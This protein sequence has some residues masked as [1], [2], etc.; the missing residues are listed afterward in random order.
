MAKDLR[1]AM[2]LAG[3]AK[4]P[5]H[6]GE[7]AALLYRQ[8]GLG[9]RASGGQ[10]FEGQG[11]AMQLAGAAKQP[12]HMGEKVALLYRQMCVGSCGA[13]VVGVRQG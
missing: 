2:Q 9:V 12:L 5:L 4:Q 10:G 1:I 6:M 3:A 8:V 11:V 7:K 13:G